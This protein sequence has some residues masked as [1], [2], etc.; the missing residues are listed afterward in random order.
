MRFLDFFRRH[1]R[2]QETASTAKQRLQVL[3]TLERAT[4][5]GP[6]FLPLMQR[7]LLEV[8]RKYVEIDERKLKIE[9]EREQ[10]MSMLAVSVELPNRM[11]G[12]PV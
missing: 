5:A 3:L 10:D 6:D 4:G 9:F 2:P 7:E 8:I 1:T 11:L 12:R